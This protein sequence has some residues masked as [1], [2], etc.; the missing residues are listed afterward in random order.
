MWAS[1]SGL[2]VPFITRHVNHRLRVT[3]DSLP[4]CAERWKFLLSHFRESHMSAIIQCLGFTVEP[5]GLIPYIGADAD[6]PSWITDSEWYSSRVTIAATGEI[7][8]LQRMIFPFQDGPSTQ[9]LA[10]LQAMEYG[11]KRA[12]NTV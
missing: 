5:L 2:F 4:V 9:D 8:I 12:G 6:T 1:L 10:N 3:A 11:N 7:Q